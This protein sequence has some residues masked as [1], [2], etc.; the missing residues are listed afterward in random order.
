MIQVHKVK[1]YFYIMNVM[2]R[3]LL[4][5]FEV[6][7]KNTTFMIYLFL[8]NLLLLCLQLHHLHLLLWVEITVA[9]YISMH[10]LKIKVAYK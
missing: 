2:F 7:M 4:R 3:L 8:K 5:V 10:G 1:K 9:H 6:I